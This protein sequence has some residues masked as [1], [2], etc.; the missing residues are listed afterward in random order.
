MPA[1]RACPGAEV[2]DRRRRRPRSPSVDQRDGGFGR[3]PKF[4]QTMTLD[5][6]LRRHLPH[7]RPGRPRRRARCRSTPWPPAASTTTSAAGSPATPS[8][9]AGWCPTSRRCSTTRPCWPGSTSTPGRSPARPGS[10]RS[11]TRPSTTCCAT[12]ATRDGG[13]FS[14]EDADCE[15]EEGKFYVWSLDEVRRDAPGTDAD[16][17]I[18]WYGVTAGGNFEGP[19]SS[20]DPVRGDLR[21]AR[22]G[23]AAPAWRLLAERETPHPARASTTRCSPSGTR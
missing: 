1:D 11:S 8:T 20:T 3:A 13:F 5:P 21:P 22:R 9:A 2:L 7:R 19:T 6:L 4:P 23:R 15:G 10:A 16:A 14:A 12:C 17:A 18:E